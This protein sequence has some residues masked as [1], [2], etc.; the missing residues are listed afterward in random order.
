M[1]VCCLVPC[2]WPLRS[3]SAT[4]VQQH[5]ANPT[6]ELRKCISM[7]IAWMVGEKEA[8]IRNEQLQSYPGSLDEFI[9]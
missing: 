1:W 4:E 8:H 2:P 9:R 3:P 5:M 7:G 6:Q